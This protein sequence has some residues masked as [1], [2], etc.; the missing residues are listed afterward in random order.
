M[1]IKR[2][3]AVLAFALPLATTVTTAAYAGDAEYCQALVQKYHAFITKYSGHSPNPGTAD[4]QVAVDQC[5][6]G[7]P[8][9][10]PVLEQKLRDA[11]VELP[12]RG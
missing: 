8:A 11:K 2:L 7:N 5:L 10:I 1:M 12:S 9:G 6:S 3:V 4:G